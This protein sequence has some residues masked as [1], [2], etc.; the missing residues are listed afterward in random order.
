M[1]S[2]LDFLTA[3]WPIL[4]PSVL[5]LAG[6]YLLMP[7]VRRYPPLWGAVCAGLALAAVALF[8][9]RTETGPIETGLFYAFSG[10]AIVSACL[11]ITLRNPV[12]SALSFAMVVL[13]T[14]GLF[15]LQAAP[16]LMAA[17]II[18]YAGAIVVTFLFVIMLAQQAGVSDADQRSREPFLAT[19]AGFV[20]LACIFAVLQRN[21]DTAALAPLDV[22]RQRVDAALQK[23][24]VEEMD[25]ALGGPPRGDAE[26]Q[27]KGY[28]RF[29][30][31]MEAIIKVRTAE[32]GEDK[33]QD[34]AK[35]PALVGTQL[36]QSALEDALVGL[37]EP[38]TRKDAKEVTAQLKLIRKLSLEVRVNAGGLRPS[39]KLK[40]SK[41]SGHSPAE[42]VPVDDDGRVKERLPRNNVAAL[43]RSLFSDYL[44][45]LELAGVLL[46]VATIGAIV[47]AGRRTEGLR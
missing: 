2:L 35:K 39:D 22:L 14:C 38:F 27:E 30:Q 21:Y 26:K 42:P 37:D 44:L 11:M 12:H 28:K 7:R 1:N 32:P 16:F 34:K 43:G 6:V 33:S 19:V 25:E 18:I 36:Q 40:L 3:F 23:Q 31:Q 15:L 5:G 13:S 46:L 29:A 20:L 24:T 9:I 4:L 45:P 10:C 17:T 41:F 8:L 47:I